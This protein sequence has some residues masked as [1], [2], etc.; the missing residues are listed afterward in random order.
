MG[1]GKCIEM[2]DSAFAVYPD[3]EINERL[4]DGDFVVKLG[5]LRNESYPGREAHGI[6]P[7]MVVGHKGMTREQ[8]VEWV[9]EYGTAAYGAGYA[10]R[11]V[12]EGIDFKELAPTAGMGRAIREGKGSFEDMSYD[13]ILRAVNVVHLVEKWPPLYNVIATNMVGEEMSL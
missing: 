5:D 9:N 12:K 3:D 11:M 7:I 10:A 8:W 1:I 4:Y 6:L 2:M 13:Y